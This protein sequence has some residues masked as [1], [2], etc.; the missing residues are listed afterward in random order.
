MLKAITCCLLLIGPT[1]WA[2]FEF[3]NSANLKMERIE[4]K[5]RNHWQERYLNQWEILGKVDIHTIDFSKLPPKYKY[6]T[7]E[8][9]GLFYFVLI[10]TGQ[11]YEFNPDE[12]V[13]KRIDKTFHSGFNFGAFQFVRNDTIFSSG[14]MGFWHYNNIQTFFDFQTK[15]WELL[16]SKGEIPKRIYTDFA[17]YS[18]REDKLYMLE[19][20]DAFSNESTREL[21]FFTCN[22]KTKTWE[23]LGEVDYDDFKSRNL[24]IAEA[25]WIKDLFVIP[26]A[27]GNFIIDPVHN[28]CY[29]YDGL[30][31]SFFNPGFRYFEKGN[32]I[33]CYKK[34]FTNNFN[35]NYSDSLDVRVLLSQSKEIGPFYHLLPSFTWQK[36]GYWGL[37]GLIMVS[38]FFNFNYWY[39]WRQ[40]KSKLAMSGVL[41]SEALDFL[42]KCFT[43][44]VNHHFSTLEITKLMGF[45][46][47][48]Y[49]T[50]RQYRS[51][52]INHINDHFNNNY[53]I[54][55]VII[56]ISSNSDKRFV[57]YVI[58]PHDFK[59]V[60][61]LLN[62]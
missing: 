34:D 53:N 19:I 7:F 32:M 59:R 39:N 44:E 31:S 20:P 36:L 29:E 6:Q 51:K 58:S 10:G 62:M 24:K 35:Q 21:S 49:D 8:S 27:S 5:S 3:I 42:E 23:K 22:L 40:L 52:L 18:K 56:R 14:G 13:L 50:Q 57:D 37:M 17:G 55:V 12:R 1:A 2:D 47:Q 41:S 46:N 45:D 48:A 60:K 38:F 26:M 54:P 28:K 30:K 43:Y 15:E 16:K 11:V 61:E 25:I 9:K 4:F 33:Y